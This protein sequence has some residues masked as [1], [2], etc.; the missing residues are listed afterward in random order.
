VE[1]QSALSPLTEYAATLRWVFIGLVFAGIALTI[2][3]RVADWK[4]GRK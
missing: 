4:R 3:A 2:Y 1:A